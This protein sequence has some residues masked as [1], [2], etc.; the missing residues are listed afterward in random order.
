MTRGSAKPRPARAMGAAR[1]ARIAVAAALVCALSMMGIQVG[2]VPWT[3]QTFAVALSGFAL[4]SADGAIAILVYLMIGATGVPVFGGMAAGI[5][6]F[7][8]PTGGYLL[9]F[10]AMAAVCGAARGRG[11]ALSAAAALLSLIPLYAA[12]AAQLSIS[13]EITYAEALRIGAAPFA[14]KDAASALLAPYASRAISG[15]RAK[16]GAGDPRA[17]G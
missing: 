13:L 17:G 11:A 8:G 4:G 10:P 3:L 12:G 9:A 16:A 6:R 15:A 5:S 1:S 7:L 2:S 14:L